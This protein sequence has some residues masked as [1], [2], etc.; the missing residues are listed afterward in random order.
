MTANFIFTSASVTAGH[1][2]KLCDQIS[3]AI[4]DQF[5][6]QDPCSRINAECAV[7]SGVVFVAARFA[8]HAVVDIPEIARHVIENVGYDQ[9]DF[10]AKDCTILTNF[11]ELPADGCRLGDETQMSDV[12]LDNVT[13][14]N[15]ATVFGYACK[16]TPT[17]LPMPIWLAHQFARQLSLVRES[18]LISGLLPDGMSEVAIEYIN[19]KP[20]RIHSMVLVASHNEVYSDNAKD[21]NAAL[22]K[23]VVDPVIEQ[24]GIGIN[25]DTH[26]YINPQGPF[27]GG[28]PK[29]H[30]GLTG[31]KV[32]IDSYGQYCRMGSAALSGKDPLRIDRTGNY[33]AR[34]AAKNVVAAGLA[35]ECE[36]LVSYCIGQARPVTVQVNTFGTGTVSDHDITMRLLDVIDFR[37]GAVIK[38]FNL[39]NLPANKEGFYR[40]LAVYGHVGRNDIDLPWEKTDLI[41]LLSG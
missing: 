7:A 36:V 16:Q 19:D 8:S 4:V 41:N 15:H 13:A 21:L 6:Q 18:K 32:A 38:Q 39:R 14:E 23:H 1:P 40:K 24:N 28:G 9:T 3:D 34:Y 2:D 29:I 35:E 5:L 31:R 37:P 22:I 10:N 26:I 33:I 12:E 20:E 25:E 11:A 30:S 27:F 17:M